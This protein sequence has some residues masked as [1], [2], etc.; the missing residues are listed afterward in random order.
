M[1][2]VI[3]TPLHNVD[4]DMDVE[5]TIFTFI[6]TLTEY[7]DKFLTWIWNFELVTLAIKYFAITIV[8]IMNRKMFYQGIPQQRITLDMDYP[9]ETE[10]LCLLFCTG[11]IFILCL[12]YFH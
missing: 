9:L 2:T 4:Y 3:N 8:G 5:Y 12:N 6:E 10:T 1:T 7:K 11:E